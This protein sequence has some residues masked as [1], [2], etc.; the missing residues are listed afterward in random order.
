LLTAFDLCLM[1][2]AM[3]QEPQQGSANVPV[4]ADEVA[5]P[6]P[7]D[8]SKD[9]IRLEAIDVFLDSGDLPLAVWQLELRSLTQDVEIVGIESGE[10]SAF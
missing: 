3:A 10:H 2:F 7:P 9:S 4:Q 8:A 6:G 1:A 5:I